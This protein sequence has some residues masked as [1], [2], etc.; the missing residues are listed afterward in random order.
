M[1]LRGPIPNRSGD[2][3][4]ERDAHKGDRAPIK[5]GIAYGARPPA[6]SKDW[7]PIAKKMWNALKKSGQSA[8]Y[9]ESDW[10]YAYHVMDDLSYYKKSNKRSSMMLSAID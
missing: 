1:G 2:Y 3:S 8:F 10:A 5:K 9:E 6:A 7:H 4:R